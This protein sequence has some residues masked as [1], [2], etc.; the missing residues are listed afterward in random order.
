MAGLTPQT[1]TPT[2]ITVHG[3]SRV[4]EIHFSSGERFDLPFEYLRVFSPSAEVRGHGPGQETLQT[5]KQEVEITDLES[6]GNYAVRPVFSDGHA[7]GIYTWEY[8]YQLGARQAQNWQQ[9]LEQL[10]KSGASRT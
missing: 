3:K 5:G 9:Y 7:S 2:S 6:I 10:A 8:L 1:P 4:L